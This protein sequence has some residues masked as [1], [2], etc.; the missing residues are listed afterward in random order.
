MKA[1]LSNFV[2]LDIGSSK[3]AGIA[4]YI[5]KKGEIRVLSQNLHYSE[6]FKSGMI[7]DLKSAE[8]SIINTIF[9]LEK[10]CD[11]NIKQVSISLSGFSTKSYYI[12][13]K[14]KLPNN[15]QISK[16]DIKKLIERTILEFKLKN[17]E[18][19]HY[20]PIEFVIDNKNVVD[21]P[22]G[23]YGKE[24]ACQLHIIT[25]DSALLM[26]LISCF[27]KYQIEVQEI[28]LSIYASGLA[29]LAEDDRKVGTLII[30]IGARTT[31]FGIF[32][33]GKLIYT[34]YVPLG[35][36]HITSDIAKAFSISLF[37]AEKLKVLY[38]NA[39]SLPLDKNTSINMEDIDPENPY[40]GDMVITSKTLSEIINPRIEEIFVMV[41]EQYQK[42]VT[43]HIVA[44]RL[45]LTG[46]GAALRGI[47][48]LASTIFQKQVRV[49]KPN[50]LAGFIEGYNPC[51][52]STAIGMVL[53]K[54]NKLYKKSLNINLGKED[55]SWIN[56]T[57]SW[58]KEN[59]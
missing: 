27:A 57:F 17:Q 46:G 24:L 29:C 59:F 52:Y 40:L 51:L 58:L 53:H 32:L 18:I 15:Q 42:I 23:I 39:I 35:S 11:K 13:H 43:N 28:I 38:G 22:I 33:F 45:V 34:G 16:Q 7:T 20:F 56:K 49:S 4:S 26:N 50:I 54:S 44:N 30:D 36:A 9:G 6:G 3:L 19:I 10:E 1:K 8:N 48:E 14:M 5:D 31:S 47:K 41:Q 21:D 37:A 2:A 12:S 25:A 55:D